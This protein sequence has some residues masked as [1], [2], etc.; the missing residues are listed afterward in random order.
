MRCTC[1][2]QLLTPKES[3]R[4]FK[5]SKEFV[6]MCSTCLATISDAVSTVEGTIS[7]DEDVEG[8]DE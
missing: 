5:E 4:R 7:D 8:W 2:N 1:C 3:V 6:D